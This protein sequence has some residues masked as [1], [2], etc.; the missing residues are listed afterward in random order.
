MLAT[1]KSV[2]FLVLLV[3]FATCVDSDNEM[4]DT[5]QIVPENLFD[6]LIDEVNPLLI[7]PVPALTPQAG[8][9]LAPGAVS[10]GSASS[11]G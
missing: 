1:A 6:E 7:L 11:R 3:A 2:V 4:T 10:R 5:G 9:P 8:A